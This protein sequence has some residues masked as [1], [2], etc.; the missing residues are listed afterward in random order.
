MHYLSSFYF[1]HVDQKFTQR[2]S[3]AMYVAEMLTPTG[4]WSHWQ[5]LENTTPP[6][7]V[8]YF[9]PKW[10]LVFPFA[11][12]QSGF[13]SVYPAALRVYFIAWRNVIL[14]WFY[15][16]RWMCCQCQEILLLVSAGRRRKLP[17]G[18][19]NSTTTCRFRQKQVVY[20]HTGRVTSPLGKETK[21]KCWS[22]IVNSKKPL[23]FMSG[24][25]EGDGFSSGWVWFFLCFFFLSFLL[26]LYL[27]QIDFTTER[28]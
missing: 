21:E 18:T 4:H 10:P 25:F 28:N 20:Y 24:G 6:L 7:L 27:V 16:K 9:P 3:L 1:V 12:L 23:S 14:Q 26:I 8:M 2:T 5:P 13:S 19:M 15:E 11:V 17:V 22:V